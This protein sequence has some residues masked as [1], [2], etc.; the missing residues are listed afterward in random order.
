MQ[1][2]NGCTLCVHYEWDVELD[3][4][5]CAAFPEGI[6]D[7]IYVG[8][9]DHRTE[10]DGDQGIRFEAANE[11]DAERYDMVMNAPRIGR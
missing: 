3:M 6:P 10:F 5:T 9:F 4:P 1:R 2:R 11:E 8:G 7:E